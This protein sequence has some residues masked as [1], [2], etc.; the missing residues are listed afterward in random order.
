VPFDCAALL[1]DVVDAVRQVYLPMSFLYGV[2]GTGPI[3]PLVLALREE[4]YT[5]PYDSINWN[6]AR[7]VCVCLRV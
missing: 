1:I 7:C 2:R 4:L 3:T 6:A 5:Q